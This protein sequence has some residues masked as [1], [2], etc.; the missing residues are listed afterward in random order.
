LKRAVSSNNENHKYNSYCGKGKTTMLS[1]FRRAIVSL[2]I[3]I[4][5]NAFAGIID[6]SITIDSSIGVND[7]K[8]T[9]TNLSDENYDIVGVSISIGDTNYNWDAFWW[10]KRYGE[11][12]P[13]DKW[14][15][16]TL[17][18]VTPDENYSGGER[19]DIA[20]ASFSGFN[21]GDVFKWI[22]DPDHDRE[23]T[24]EDYREIMF[25][26]GSNPNA[27]ISVDFFYNGSINQPILFLSNSLSAPSLDRSLNIAPDTSLAKTVDKRYETLSFSLADT[28]PGAED[29]KSYNFV[30]SENNAL[31]TFTQSSATSIPE[32]TTI[33][34]MGL[35]LIGLVASRKKRK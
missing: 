14:G 21:A 35:G 27:V 4:S 2:V 16:L 7:P 31:R 25:N 17:L 1:T 24:Y 15:D 22:M 33:T 10:N 8:F 26:N 18:H 9:L 5:S 34:I 3:L 12:T 19:A 30:A 20:K 11:R 13:V 32:P 29:V 23:N 6:F 28:V